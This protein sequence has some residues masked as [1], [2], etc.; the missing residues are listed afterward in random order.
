MTVHT[1][2]QRSLIT[3][4]VFAQAVDHCLR[5]FQFRSSPSC[6]VV[7]NWNVLAWAASRTTSLYH[8]VERL[9]PNAQGQIFWN[10][11]RANL[12]KQTPALERRL[13]E[14]LRFPG[15]LPWLRGR[16]FTIA[17]DYHAIPYYGLPQKVTGNS[18][19]ANPNAARP[20]STPTPRLAWSSP[21]GDTPWR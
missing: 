17:I 4:A 19:V 15:F 13:N 2:H 1:P 6:S 20:D 12:P 14:L 3:Q 16:L 10:R 11:L 7:M 9:Y 5:V 21:V 18:D 8:A